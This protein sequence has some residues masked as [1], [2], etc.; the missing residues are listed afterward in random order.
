M[1]S[2]VLPLRSP[3]PKP[4]LT[5][6]LEWLATVVDDVI[7][8]DGSAPEVF[9]VHDSWW[10]ATVRH[11]PVPEDRRTVMGKVGGVVTGLDLALHDRVVVADDDVRYDEQTLLRMERLLDHADVVRPQNVFTDWPWHAWW[12]T[13]RTLLARVTGGDWPGTLGV[14]RTPLLRAG[15]YAGDVM[16]ENLELVRT[17]Q[18]GGGREHVA[19]DVYV[20]RHPPSVQH[21]WS[22]RIRQAYDELARPLRMIGFL[23]IVPSLLVGGRRAA[24]VL[25]G[26]SL[27]AAECGRQ[28][29]GGADVFPPVTTLAAPVWL[30]E[31]AVTSWIALG[32]RVLNGGVRYGDV[33]VPR[34]STSRRALRR[35]ACEQMPRGSGNSPAFPPSHPGVPAGNGAT[36][37]GRASSVPSEA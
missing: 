1:L 27:A 30:A 6:Y 4:G 34:A 14:R 10:S 26:A 13:G 2:Y 24:F 7:V 15:G 36:R 37:E 3:T 17:V 21:F 35:R 5:G 20:P 28:R 9:G 32:T 19:F 23:A 25:I 16:F 8:V 33:L 12:D 11:V 29:A 31:R 22:Q 18:A